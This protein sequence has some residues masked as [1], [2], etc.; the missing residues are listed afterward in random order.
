MASQ[1]V[2]GNSV[3]VLDRD[4]VVSAYTV[5]CTCTVYTC[6]PLSSDLDLSRHRPIADEKSGENK[7]TVNLFF[8]LAAFIRV[9]TV[10][11][12][13]PGPH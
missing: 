7:K 3:T 5:V 4:T 6:S 11:F 1:F 13:S 2:K 10:C 12:F 8:P 9:A